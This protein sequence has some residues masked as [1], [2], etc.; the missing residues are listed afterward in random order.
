MAKKSA[1]KKKP[2]ALKKFFLAA[3]AYA[4]LAQ[5]LHSIGAFLTM[6]Y[7]TDPAYFGLWSSLMM[8]T[9]G[10]PGVEFFA[11]SL[12]F[13][14]VI[15]LIFAYL[16]HRLKGTVSGITFGLLLFA[17]SCVPGYLSTYLLLAVPTLLLVSWAVEGLVVSIL[18]GL[19]IASLMK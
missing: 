9:N 17:V 12:I 7:Y 3:L 11:V 5:I 4:I 14:F 2:S 19:A 6:S 1:K 13:S 10:P 8:P 16:Y 15:G 18:G